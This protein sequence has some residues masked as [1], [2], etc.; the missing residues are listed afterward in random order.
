MS[1]RGEK[2]QVEVLAVLNAADGALSAYEVLHEL[3][4]LHPKIAPPTIYNALEALI[5]KG[6]VH[7][8]ESLNA[9]IARQRDE[10]HHPSDISICDD[11]GLVE[12]RAAPDLLKTL[13][14]LVEEMGFAPQCHVIEVH[15]VCASCTSY[16]K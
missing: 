11:C 4:T 2:I 10:A 16:S 6:K 7:R 12:E 5:R 13:T 1:K 8:V 15:G 14:N 3:Q 9:N